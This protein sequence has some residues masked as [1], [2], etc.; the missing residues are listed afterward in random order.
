MQFPRFLAVATLA[1]AAVG[2]QAKTEDLGVLTSSGTTFGNIFFWST[3][4]FTDYYT[5]SI[6][7]TSTVSG[8]T[9]D[10]SYVLFFTKDVALKS[11]TLTSG[12]SSTVLASD[13]SASS[14]SFAGLSEGSYTLAVNGAVSG[15][16]AIAGAYSGTIKA[17]S[18]P[19]A[20]P[21]PEASDFAMTAL[22]LAGVG[23]LVRRRKAA[24]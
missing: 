3:S 21:A 19:V 4:D 16:L 6:A 7:D 2:A 17:V 8:Y 11:L 12:G 5:F 10:T 23:L 14:F 9:A 18:A 20:S 1:L 13:T 22:G 24:R 15:S